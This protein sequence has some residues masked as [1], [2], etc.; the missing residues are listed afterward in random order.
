MQGCHKPLI[1]KKI[2]YPQSTK[3]NEVKCNK[4]RFACREYSPG[5]GPLRGFQIHSVP[6]GYA[7]LLALAASVVMRLLVFKA[8]ERERCMGREGKLEC[9]G[10][11]LTKIQ[12]FFLK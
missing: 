2:T 7:V 6:S 11:L 10:L 4:A 12:S 9:Q 3:H 5:I 1:C 8:T